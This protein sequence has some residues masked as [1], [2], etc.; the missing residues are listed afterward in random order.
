MS[1]IDGRREQGTATG[2]SRR[3]VQ[4][5]PSSGR[6]LCFPF[7]LG[8]LMG[9]IRSGQLQ[10]DGSK[11]R[12]STKPTGGSRRGVRMDQAWPLDGSDPMSAI[13]G[14]REQGTLSPLSL[15]SLFSLFSLLSIRTQPKTSQKNHQSTRQTAVLTYQTARYY[16][17][18]NWPSEWIRFDHPN[19]PRPPSKGGSN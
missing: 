5:E 2:G 9:P 6:L 17:R 3:G 1:A 11:A 16:L 13:E 18:Q 19:R 15:L 10:V 14:R 7:K 8:H 4:L 12:G